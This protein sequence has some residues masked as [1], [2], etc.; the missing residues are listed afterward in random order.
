MK[1]DIIFDGIGEPM[2]DI[3]ENAINK[4]SV[5]LEWT[6]STLDIN[7]NNKSL[8][9]EI[10]AREDISALERA[11]IISSY[12]K[13]IREYVNQADIARIAV[14]NLKPDAKPEKVNDNWIIFFFDKARTVTEDD[15]KIIWGKILAGEINAPGTFSKQLLHTLSI[16][17]SS[18]AKRFQ[19]IRSSC[20]YVPPHLYTFI[21]RTNRSIIRNNDKYKNLDLN[22]KDFRELD[23]LGIIKYRY[24][25]FYTIHNSH[26]K[27]YYGKKMITLN[28]NRNQIE[29][30]NVSLTDIG[31]Q[32]CRISPMVVDDRVLDICM[33]TWRTLG[34]NPY[35]EELSM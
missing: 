14:E 25:H 15:V 11:A 31:K 18:M 21:Y 20:F 6:A 8:I 33:D 28:T 35:I 4:I 3:R 30:G 7:Q 34:Y 17:D 24:P 26:K 27:I 32:L 9:A 16:M 29:T 22:Y 5:G 10:L 19:K 1:C 23:N 2:K 12:K 13:T